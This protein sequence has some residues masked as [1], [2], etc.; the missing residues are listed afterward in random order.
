MLKEFQGRELLN[1]DRLG[2]ERTGP[3][4]GPRSI[5][6]QLY[7]DW[8]KSDIL[9]N[10]SHIKT[11]GLFIKEYLTREMVNVEYR[12]RLAYKDHLLFL[13]GRGN[14]SVKVINLVELANHIEKCKKFPAL[15]QQQGK[16]QAQPQAGQHHVLM[17]VDPAQQ[18]T[19][20]IPQM[21]PQQNFAQ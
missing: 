19:G 12:A 3:N 8:R 7:S 16:P 6:V 5:K 10:R 11:Q 13:T 18:P 17:Q 14:P 15:I 2:R 21:I 20:F 1:V 4:P 9:A